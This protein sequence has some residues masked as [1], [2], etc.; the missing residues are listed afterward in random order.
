M[1]IELQNDMI[2]S[3]T[4]LAGI[5]ETKPDYMRKAIEEAGIEILKMNRRPTQQYV[6]LRAIHDH[7]VGKHGSA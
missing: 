1:A 2:I 5:L 3:I 6:A 7:L 4:E